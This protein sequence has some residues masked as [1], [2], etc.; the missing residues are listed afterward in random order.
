M[1]NIIIQLDKC[2]PAVVTKYLQKN[3]LSLEGDFATQVA[4]LQGQQDTLGHK[5]LAHCDVCGGDGYYDEPCCFCGEEESPEGKPE[6][7]AEKPVPFE[8]TAKKKTAKKKAV[9]K[10]AKKKVVKKTAKKKNTAVT[11][12]ASGEVQDVSMLDESLERLHNAERAGVRSVWEMGKELN[13]MRE[14]SLYTLRTDKTTGA[15]LYSS[16]KE[17]VEGELN[18]TRPYAS[19]IMLATANFSE[20]EVIKIGVSK[21]YLL[22]GLKEERRAPLLEKVNAGATRREISDEV[23]RIGSS[24]RNTLDKGGFTGKP[25]KGPAPKQTAKEPVKSESLTVLNFEKPNRTLK[26]MLGANPAK[27]ANGNPVATEITENGVVI[28]YKLVKK[29]GQLQLQISGK[30]SS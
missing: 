9:K 28:T 20:K 4:R 23:A 3:N 8:R 27:N 25:G 22:V 10:T 12:A 17:F 7:P 1:S 30:R 21:L 14:K 18:I 19:K 2:V 11:A 5:N 24:G 16:W 6:K 15:P 13:L 26:F 29:D